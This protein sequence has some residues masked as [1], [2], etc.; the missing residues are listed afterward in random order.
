LPLRLSIDD[1]WDEISSR[2]DSASKT[3]ELSNVLKT[4]SSSQWYETFSRE[5]F[6][7]ITAAASDL[8]I[9]YSQLPAWAEIGVVLAPIFSLAVGILYSLSFPP[10]NY[11]S[12]M[13]PYLRGN[14]DPIQAR[15]FYSRHKLL[16]LQ[17]VLQMLRLSNLFIINLL[18]DKYVFKSEERNRAKRAEELLV[19]ITQLG[20]TAIKS[21]S[22]GGYNCLLM[23][24]CPSEE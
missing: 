23:F 5:W 19:L 11:R 16:V 7:V 10:D 22:R 12:G 15:V 3:V 18:L 2:I 1:T 20:P 8:G 4:I 13:E 9:V 14:Y 17:R 21:K 24:I 6:R